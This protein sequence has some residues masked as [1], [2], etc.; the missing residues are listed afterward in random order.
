MSVLEPVTPPSY[1]DV[2]PFDH[3]RAEAA[4]RE[5]LIAIGEDPDRDG[6]RDTPGRVARSYEELVRG[7][8]STLPASQ[9]V[10]LVVLGLT[11]VVAA[12]LLVVFPGASLVVLAR[13]GGV[14]LLVLGVLTLLTGVR[15]PR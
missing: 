2:P 5:L 9:R 10:A 4:V 15:R 14:L 8:R 11:S 6:L 13:L 1:A 7:I 3:A 12:V